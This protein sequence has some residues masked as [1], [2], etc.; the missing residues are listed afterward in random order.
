MFSTSSFYVSYTLFLPV[1]LANLCHVFQA[2]FVIVFRFNL[3]SFFHVNFFSCFC[4][5]FFS[6]YLHLN[7]CCVFRAHF[8]LCNSCYSM[9][10]FFF[11]A[12]FF[13]FL[14]LIYVV[15]FMLIY[16]VFFVLFCTYYNDKELKQGW[17][18][19]LSA[20]GNYNMLQYQD[21]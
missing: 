16:V 20:H 7:L 13:V 11:H 17:E 6:V 2:Y 10:G 4:A 18:L 8:F 3:C 9:V 15:F 1:F 5:N 19:T 12:N 21:N 14:L